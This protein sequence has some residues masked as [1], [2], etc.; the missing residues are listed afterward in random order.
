MTRKYKSTPSVH[1]EPVEFGKSVTTGNQKMHDYLD[2]LETSVTAN[3]SKASH[4]I[5]RI[6]VYLMM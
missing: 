4:V 1:V 6:F 5:R 2:I 3:I